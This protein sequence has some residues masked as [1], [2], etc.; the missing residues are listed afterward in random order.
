MAAGSEVVVAVGTVDLWVEIIVSGGGVTG[1]DVS[2]D[3]SVSLVVMVFSDV[4][5]SLVGTAV[6]AVTVVRVGTGAG[7][8]MVVRRETVSVVS[9]CSVRLTV[10]TNLVVG[11]TPNVVAVPGLGATVGGPGVVDV[12]VTAGGLV[13]MV[14]LA[15]TGLTVDL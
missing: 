8:V 13:A 12:I 15:E 5:D 7:A 2:G 1:W 9:A 14:T 6:D 4:A 10:V 11:G 3:T